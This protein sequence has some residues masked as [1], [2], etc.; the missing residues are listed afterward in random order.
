MGVR[1]IQFRKLL[2]SLLLSW[3][4]LLGA[5]GLAGAVAPPLSVN[6]VVSEPVPANGEVTF[7]AENIFGTTLYISL[8]RDFNDDGVITEGADFALFNDVLVDNGPDRG[9]LFSADADTTPGAITAAFNTTGGAYMEMGTYV[10]RVTDHISPPADVL[11][12]VAPPAPLPNSSL[13]GTAY[14]INTGL[15]LA[16]TM[17]YATQTDPLTGNAVLRAVGFSHDTDVDG[18]N[19]EIPIA[20]LDGD[21][22]NVYVANSSPLSLQALH[23]AAEP[24][25]VYSGPNYL[26]INVE[27]PD[28]EH[29]GTVVTY[30]DELTPAPRVW[31]FAKEN[32]G[33]PF[34]FNLLSSSA[35]SGPTGAFDLPVKA[36]VP[37]WSLLT[38][39]VNSEYFTSLILAN[40]D[41][42]LG[43]RISA[44]CTTV[45]GDNGFEG[46]IFENL[47]ACASAEPPANV[48]F[49]A[50][51][52]TADLQVNVVSE[53]NYPV[54]GVLAHAQ[55][56]GD[57]PH[58]L[59]GAG[60]YSDSD[61]QARL[62]LREGDWNVGLCTSC[63]VNIVKNGGSNN[64]G[65]GEGYGDEVE[66]VPGPSVAGHP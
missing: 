27:T 57:V 42:S 55:G 46:L 41:Y 29:A 47:S 5:F 10:L 58:A 11:F 63:H 45:T 26:S 51:P 16:N 48:Q 35:I 31:I 2:G 66:M 6:L 22:V 65:L 18:L 37:S 20:D 21:T 56:A 52:H 39:T 3:A 4:L 40:G 64:N 19:F 62:L 36:S 8:H 44:D 53:D 59:L 7:Q 54:E 23:R 43:A 30:L 32:N 12:T 49:V 25:P 28:A 24:V 60:G 14:D 15:E 34:S 9:M 61:G 33:D 50:V 38:D 1:L 17:I 13:Y